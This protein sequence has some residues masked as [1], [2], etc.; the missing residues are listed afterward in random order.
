MTMGVT[1]GRGVM[2]SFVSGGLGRG[3]TEM[4]RA[5]SSLHNVY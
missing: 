2:L 1:L 4:L 3:V 5:I